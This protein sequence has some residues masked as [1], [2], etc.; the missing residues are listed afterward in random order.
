[1]QQ[2]IASLVMDGMI[3]AGTR[4]HEATI[5]LSP[6]ENQEKCRHVDTILDG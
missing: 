3:F 4:P 1:M 6:R 2:P 5:G